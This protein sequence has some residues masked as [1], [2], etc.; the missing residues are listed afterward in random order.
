VRDFKFEK[1]TKKRNFF[2]TLFYIIKENSE[3][4]SS[5]FIR[6]YLKILFR[7]IEIIKNLKFFSLLI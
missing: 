2:F 5:Q 6:F 7:T 4:I 3:Q 1:K